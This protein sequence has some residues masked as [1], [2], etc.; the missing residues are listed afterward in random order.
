MI[1][2]PHESKELLLKILEKH[3]PHLTEHTFDKSLCKYTDYTRE[4]YIALTMAVADEF[5]A[6]GL[7]EDLEPNEYGLRCEELIDEIM[8]FVFLLERPSMTGVQ[9]IKHRV[10]IL[11]FYVTTNSLHDGMVAFTDLS[12]DC[13]RV[14]VDVTSLESRPRVEMTFRGVTDWQIK[15]DGYIFASNIAFENG[16]IIWADACRF[17]SEILKKSHYVRAASME[18]VI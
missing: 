3:A 13:L 16:G 15:N 17:D 2:L 6:E 5:H 18:W 1:Q 14:D 10:D 11:A 7:R 4:D 8:A 9:K 12:G